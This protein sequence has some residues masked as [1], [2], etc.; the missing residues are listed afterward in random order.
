MLCLLASL[1][2]AYRQ[3]P[4]TR[5]IDSGIDTHLCLQIVLLLYRKVTLLFIDRYWNI[6][7]MYFFRDKL[8][9]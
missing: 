1:K 3:A 2:H 8:G 4:Q 7:E 6:I 5:L 9:H